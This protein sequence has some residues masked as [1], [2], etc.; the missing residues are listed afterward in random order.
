M[1]D[2]TV[3]GEAPVAQ[4]VRAVLVS[5]EAAVTAFEVAAPTKIAGSPADRAEETFGAEV[6]EG[7]EGSAHQRQHK[8]SSRA[9]QC[10]RRTRR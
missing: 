4:A 6:A 5:P 7:G 10:Q 2:H 8:F 3:V 9:S 1:A